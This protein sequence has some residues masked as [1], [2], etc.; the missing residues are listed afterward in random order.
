MGTPFYP[1]ANHL[2]FDA[3]EKIM[4][5]V[6]Q[7]NREGKYRA[8]A[9]L[10][11][12]HEEQKSEFREKRDS[13]HASPDS[14][15]PVSSYRHDNDRYGGGRG[16]SG[17]GSRGGGR[18]GRGGGQ[19]HGGGRDRD[20]GGYAGRGY[21]G[22]GRGGGGGGRGG[23]GGFQ[24]KNKDK[25]QPKSSRRTDD[26]SDGD[27]DRGQDHGQDRAK[28]MVNDKTNPDSV[29]VNESSDSPV[30]PAKPIL[31]LKPRAD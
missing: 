22:G 18:G 5:I 25:Y 7:L 19:F 21:A 27:Q 9:T 4:H 3:I 14:D 10:I 23:R 11:S 26:G 12:L 13:D 30:G 20:D 17:S 31:T 29:H 16:G 6:F 24:V 15:S 2:D 1:N 28:E 8:L